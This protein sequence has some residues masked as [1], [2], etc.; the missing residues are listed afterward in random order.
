MRCTADRRGRSA[1]PLEARTVAEPPQFLAL[2]REI[3]ASLLEQ[4]A[5]SRSPSSRD[6]LGRKPAVRSRPGPGLAACEARPADGP[7][8][9]EPVLRLSSNFRMVLVSRSLANQERCPG[10][11]LIV[12]LELRHAANQGLLFPKRRLPS[13]GDDLGRPASR[14]QDPRHHASSPCRRL[15]DGVEQVAMGEPQ[16]DSHDRARRRGPSCR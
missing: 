5:S 15:V 13:V 11:H 14:D 12:P 16:R 2:G 8:P 4:A 9:A 3:A 1:R 7:L 6:L 10:Q